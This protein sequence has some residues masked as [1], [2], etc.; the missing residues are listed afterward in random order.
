[1]VVVALAGIGAGRAMS[2]GPL[3]NGRLAFAGIIGAAVGLIC[4]KV[5]EYCR[6]RP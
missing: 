2:Q 1:M 5:V 3:S 4:F 6:R